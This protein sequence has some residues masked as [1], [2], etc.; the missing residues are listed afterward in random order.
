MQKNAMSGEC[1]SDFQSESPC[2]SAH[3]FTSQW[4]YQNDFCCLLR[5]IDN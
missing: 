2:K 3:R 5:V 4:S 1:I